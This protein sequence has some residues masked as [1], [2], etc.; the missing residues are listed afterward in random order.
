MSFPLSSSSTAALAGAS[1]LEILS[2]FTF[3][4]SPLSLDFSSLTE[5]L[6][7]DVF[8]FTLL[9]NISD[10]LLR[11]DRVIPLLL[12]FLLLA[13]LFLEPVERAEVGLSDSPAPLLVEAS[14]VVE[15]PRFR[16]SEAFFNEDKVIPLFEVLA[17]LSWLSIDPLSRLLLKLRRSAVEEA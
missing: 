10:A 17:F 15:D 12:V 16:N 2:S 13:L 8:P 6:A 9:P 5:G 14:E 4:L 11:D 7:N 1:W 3:F